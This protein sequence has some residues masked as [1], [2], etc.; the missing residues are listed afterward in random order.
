MNHHDC[1]V[2]RDLKAAHGDALLSVYTRAQALA[3]GVLID[4]TKLYPSDTRLFRWPVACTIPV[5]ERVRKHADANGNAAVWYLCLMAIKG[6]T[7]IIS[8]S[9]HL[10]ACHIPIDNPR[11]TEFKINVGPGDN[12]EPV[13][14]IMMPYED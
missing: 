1:A 13:I 7:K 14:T 5:W 3:D 11:P 4:L 12:Y 2:V 10:F 9:E 8:E 6:K